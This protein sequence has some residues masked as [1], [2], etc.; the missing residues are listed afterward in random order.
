FA[1][2]LGIGVGISMFTAVTC[3]RTLMLV[4]VLGLPGVRQ[5]PELFCP[6]LPSQ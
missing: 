2:T 4:T 1:V 5:K 6:N 3:S